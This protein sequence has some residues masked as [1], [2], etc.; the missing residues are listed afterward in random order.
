[1]R[2]NIIQQQ[3]ETIQYKF[4]YITEHVLKHAKPPNALSKENMFHPNIKYIPSKYRTFNEY[5]LMKKFEEAGFIE[6]DKKHQIYKA[7][8]NKGFPRLLVSTNDPLLLRLSLERNSEFYQ[9]IETLPPP[10]KQWLI[11]IN[12]IQPNDIIDKQSNKIAFEQTIGNYLYNSMIP[13]VYGNN[14][15]TLLA[16]VKRSMKLAPT[17]DSKITTDFLKY[18]KQIILKEVGEYLKHFS[19][20]YSQWYNHLNKQKQDL[21]KP[22]HMYYHQPEKFYQDYTNKEIKKILTECYEAIVKAELQSPDGKPRLVCSIPQR[23]KYIMG[24]ITWS[25]E[26]IFSKHFN[27]YCGNKNL[28]QISELINQYKNLGF[29]K[30]VEGDGSAFDN[31]Q[32]VTLKEVDRFIYRQIYNKIYH[33]PLK[34]FKKYSQ[35]YYKKMKVKYN[36]NN[37]LHTFMTYF[38]LGTVFS[39][40]CDTTLCNTIRMALYNRYINDKSGLIYGKDY[41]LFSKGDDFTILYKNY[42]SDEF[43]K[44]I[45]SKYMLPSSSSP[46][47]ADTRIYGLGQV[48]KFLTIGDLNT[49][50][51]CSLRSWFKNPQRDIILTRDPI[52]LYNLAKF[53]IK[54]KQYNYQQRAQYNWDLALSYLINY[55]KINIFEIIAAKHLQQYEYYKSKVENFKLNT[56]NLIT[57]LQQGLARQHIENNVE[58]IGP[59]TIFYD[60]IGREE[61]YK[62]Q[63]SYW[64]TM[65]R[66]TQMAEYKLSDNEAQYINKQINDEFDLN[67]LCME[68]D[69]KPNEVETMIN[70][71]NTFIFENYVD[72]KIKYTNEQEQNCKKS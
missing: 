20:D 3:D 62:I 21:I 68:L 8:K 52:K 5:L 25:L 37:K 29:E 48:L 26:E 28:N 15:Q 4:T 16:A 66:I 13:I 54:Y 43:I 64:E 11:T 38:T 39:G 9:S 22:I 72:P 56:H 65:K 49:F 7:L 45:Y 14:K 10:I 47:I 1:M 44:K 41:V 23:I 51:F 35:M 59:Y 24:P 69:I 6:Y 32:D 67:Q 70:K 40:D 42:V 46:D 33:V 60:T 36:E 18:S 53:S 71:Y 2:V 55:K 30:V 50:T 61:F 57:N 34:E 63:G 58:Q 27:G 12:N 31:T 19:Y 17:P